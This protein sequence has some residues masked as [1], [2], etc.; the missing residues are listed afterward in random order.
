MLKRQHACSGALFKRLQIDKVADAVAHYRCGLR[1]RQ[2]IREQDRPLEKLL[3]RV[4]KKVIQTRGHFNFSLVLLAAEDR[5]LAREHQTFIKGRLHQCLL[6][7]GETMGFLFNTRE[8]AL[9]AAAGDVGGR[10]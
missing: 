7:F 10:C 1:L 6:H 9:N 8:Q 3:R 5:L 4:L 2:F